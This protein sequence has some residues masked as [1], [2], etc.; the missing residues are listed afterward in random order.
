MRRVTFAAAILAA[1]ALS[2]V[3]SAHG[4]GSI[5][6]LPVPGWLF[7]YAAVLVLVVSFV[8]LGL[9]WRRPRLEESDSARPLPT[10]AQTVLLAPALRVAL[11]AISFALLVLVT[12]AALFG[13]NN[14]DRNVAPTFVYVVFW[15]GLVPLSVVFG[16][17]WSV[18]NPWRAA[19]DGVAWVLARAG[20]DARPPRTYPE[21]L[22]R[23]PGAILLFA[24]AA[25]ELAYQ[26][27]A[28]PR[29][30]GAAILLYSGITW[31]GMAL[32]GRRA[33]L[34]NGEAFS[35]Y[36]GLL[37]RMSPFTMRAADGMTEIVARPPL[38]GLARRRYERPGTLAFVAVML[39]SVAFDGFSRT[40][41]WLDRRYSIERE[42]AFTNANLSELLVTALY[43][44][45]LILAV[46][47]VALAYL[48]AVGAAQAATGPRQ[49][50]A[51]AF[52]GSL[53]PIAVAYVVAHYFSFVVLR[54]QYAIPLAS[55]PFGW[56]WNVVGT[57]GYEPDLGLLTPNL[58]WYVQV[59][60]LVIGHVLGLVL[61][62][63]RA[64][65]LFRSGRSALRAQYALLAL[66]VLYT[67]GGLWLLS[68]G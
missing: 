15:L 6:D 58:V 53:V 3:A 64:V 36:F 48:L 38:V 50:L 40:T 60:A 19:A 65:S 32:V 55:D 2:P 41:W 27:A 34:Q 24:F 51:G 42:Y 44:A 43:L 47:L 37:A 67:V 16:N 26:H 10:W 54:G 11:Q 9:L 4:I 18:L 39:G 14:Y 13:E 66:M 29:P 33:W 49:R 31:A 7:Y 45:G 61:A 22:G 62:H 63:D 12:A 30:L 57:G 56:G 59:A 52:L 68:N 35:I 23:W 17:V 46:A 21:R 1:L 28:D 20:V 8:G 5:R 25:L